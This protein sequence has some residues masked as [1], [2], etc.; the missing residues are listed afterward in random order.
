ML[1]TFSIQPDGSCLAVIS[2]DMG[3][4]F[5][6]DTVVLPVEVIN[7]FMNSCGDGVTSYKDDLTALVLAHKG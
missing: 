6:D 2:T 3:D 5:Q 1:K 4:Y 7:D